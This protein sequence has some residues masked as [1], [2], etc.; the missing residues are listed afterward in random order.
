MVV[1]RRHSEPLTS[2]TSNAVEHEHFSIIGLHK[3]TQSQTFQPNL[4]DDSAANHKDAGYLDMP[5]PGGG[6]EALGMTNP[7]TFFAEARP[8]GLDQI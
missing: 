4:V 6:G 1:T 8:P 5:L 3:F 2:L 7:R